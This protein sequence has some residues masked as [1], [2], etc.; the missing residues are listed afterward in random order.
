VRGT[1]VSTYTVATTVTLPSVNDFPN[2]TPC[3]RQRVQDG[4]TNVL[5][6]HEQQHVSAFRTYNGTTRQAFDMTICRGAFNAAMQSLHDS[7]QSARQAAAQA[8]SDALDP[9]QFDVDLNCDEPVAEVKHA[10]AAGAPVPQTIAPETETAG[11]G[12]DELES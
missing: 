7:E 6:S 5:A 3:Q 2:L 11:P 9:F 4:I 8:R 1:L 10:A 12:A